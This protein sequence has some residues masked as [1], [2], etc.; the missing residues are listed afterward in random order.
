MEKKI[1]AVYKHSEG[2]RRYVARYL[3]G[4]PDETLEDAFA[5]KLVQNV[6]KSYMPGGCNYNPWKAGE[7]DA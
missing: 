1:Q 6:A 7:V 5:N 4:H 3:N 2:F